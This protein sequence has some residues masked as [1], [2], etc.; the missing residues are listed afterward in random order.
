MKW[1]L[2]QMM[3]IRAEQLAQRLVPYLPLDGRVLDIGSG[4]GHNAA[5]LARRGRFDIVEADVTDIHVVGPGPLRCDGQTLPFAD[6]VFNAALL[7][8]VLPYP[9]DPLQLLYEAGRVT[10]GRVLVLQ[11]TYRSWIGRT[12]L[13]ISEFFWGPVAF[14][15][16][17]ALRLIG[18]ARF[19]LQARRYFSRPDLQ[20]LAQQA[21]LHVQILQPEPWF[22]LPVSYDLLV[23][24]RPYADST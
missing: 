7:V 1:F 22:G 24:A 14:L 4:T 21:G 16:A 12:A 9:P 13:A 10:D 23:L 3:M 18:P 8:F 15:G 2:H 20:R 11:S 6:R 17:R 5:A 19:T